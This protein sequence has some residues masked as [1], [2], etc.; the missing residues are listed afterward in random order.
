MSS[1][2]GIALSGLRDADLRIAASAHNRANAL[3]RDFVPR[4]V[5]STAVPDGGVS[6]R[7]A[8]QASP[9]FDARVDETAMGLSK[10][11]LVDEVAGSMMAVASFKANLATLQTAADLDQVLMSIKA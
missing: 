4:Q 9:E 6:S 10:T 5:V 7:I 3:T 2:F 1:V 11:N 8:P